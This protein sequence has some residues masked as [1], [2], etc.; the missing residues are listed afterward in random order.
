MSEEAAALAEG[1]QDDRSLSTEDFPEDEDFVGSR[2][3]FPWWHRGPAEVCIWR[4]IAEYAYATLGRP[5]DL[6][7]FGTAWSGHYRQRH[8][9]FHCGSA[10][11]LGL[12][13]V[14][15]CICPQLLEEFNSSDTLGRFVECFIELAK[16]LIW[17]FKS[18]P[19]S[20]DAQRLAGYEKVM[21][22][23]TLMKTTL[24]LRQLAGQAL[25]LYCQP[26]WRMGYAPF[27]RVLCAC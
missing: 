24:P 15:V 8:S 17:P 13:L 3:V 20:L 4:T 14:A 22:M 7:G 9:S 26:N 18:L 21:L 5:S 19:D 10:C 23:S 6:G 12:S 2:A 1:S 25:G 27:H 11:T 16:W